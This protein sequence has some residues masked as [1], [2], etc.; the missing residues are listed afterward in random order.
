[1]STHVKEGISKGSGEPVKVA[2]KKHRWYLGGIASA[3][4]ACCTHPLDLL[5]VLSIFLT[6]CWEAYLTRAI[7]GFNTMWT[8][9]KNAAIFLSCIYFVLKYFSWGGVGG[10]R[11]LSF[12]FIRFRSICWLT[13]HLFILKI[14]R[15]EPLFSFESDP[16]N[17]SLFLKVKPSKWKIIRIKAILCSTCPTSP[18]RYPATAVDP[19]CSLGK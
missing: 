17:R 2:A 18:F 11:R 9:K 8:R 5:K 1:M 16:L 4:A 7:I 19:C 3:M 15:A 13:R 12:Q 14:I 6:R 10:S